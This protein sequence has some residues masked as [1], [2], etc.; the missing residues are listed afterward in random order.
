MLVLIL[1]SMHLPAGTV[2]GVVFA[3]YPFIVLWVILNGYVREVTGWHHPGRPSR[4]HR[5]LFQIHTGLHIGTHRT[6]GDEKRLNRAAANTSRATPE[7]LAVYFSP[8]R[9]WQRALRNNIIIVV[10]LGIVCGMTTY[11]RLT[12]QLTTFLLVFGMNDLAYFLVARKRKRHHASLPVS[13]PTRSFWATRKAKDILG[14]DT[15]TVGATPKMTAS[16]EPRL[17][18][19]VPPPVIAR[20]IANEMGCSAT[21]AM[22]LLKLAPDRGR[23][24][25]PD[26]YAALSRS[27]ETVQEIISSHTEG[28]VRFAWATTA[29]PRMLSWFPVATSLPSQVLFRDYL[30]GIESARPGTQAVG[31][32]EDKGIFYADYNGDTPWHIR[33]AGS[34]T[35][36]STGFLVKAA[37]IC[38]QDPEAEIYCVDTKQVSFEHLHNIPGVK[39]FD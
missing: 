13:M 17:V 16:G 6:Y 29:S 12:V 35:G 24:S 28:K 36:K 1:H 23:M 27:R 31:V 4:M 38:H 37:Q 32:K 30:S 22:G 2:F 18:S 3:G 10:L 39:V 9:R 26:S 11:P 7:G 14:R 34:G 33:A 20:L 21:E 8:L 15:V 19:G 25:L 5:L